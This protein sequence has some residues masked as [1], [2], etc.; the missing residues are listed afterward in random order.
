MSDALTQRQFAMLVAIEAGTFDLRTLRHDGQR[1]F[2]WRT[3]LR[4]ALAV[5]LPGGTAHVTW[6]G[7]S[8][9]YAARLGQSLARRAAS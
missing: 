3:L 5:E 2:T 1:L 9:L 8:L 4:R 7:S 6:R